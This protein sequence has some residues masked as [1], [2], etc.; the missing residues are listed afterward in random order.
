MRT[1]AFELATMSECSLALSSIH[2]DSGSPPKTGLIFVV[3]Q[4]EKMLTTTA[5]PTKTKK[6]RSNCFSNAAI[7]HFDNAGLF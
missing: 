1:I 3:A 6:Y 2:L 5:T 4:S 7:H